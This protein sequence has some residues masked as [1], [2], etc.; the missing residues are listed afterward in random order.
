MNTSI[1][2]AKSIV[3]VIALLCGLLAPVFGSIVLFLL[4]RLNAGGEVTL[5][6]G[7]TPM[8]WPMWL[9]GVSVY[10]LVSSGPPAALLGAVGASLVLGLRRRGARSVIVAPASALLGVIAGVLCMMVPLAFSSPWLGR[11][12]ALAAIRRVGLDPGNPYMMAAAVTGMF[13]GLGIWLVVG[14]QHTG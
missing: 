11:Q 1:T 4:A 12:E 14:R 6:P 8:P 5:A 13:F 7:V 2:D 9:A 3:L 10:A